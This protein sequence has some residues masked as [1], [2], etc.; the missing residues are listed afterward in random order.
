MVGQSQ[1]GSHRTFFT[2]IQLLQAGPACIVLVLFILYCTTCCL[3]SEI[4]RK[5]LVCNFRQA[6]SLGCLIDRHMARNPGHLSPRSSTR[7]ILQNSRKNNT[8][9]ERRAGTQVDYLQLNS[10]SS[11]VLFDTARK[12]HKREKLY[13]VER[14]I[15]R[16]KKQYVRFS[17]IKFFLTLSFLCNLDNAQCIGRSF[18]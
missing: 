18:P 8:A 16:R 10:L 7:L 9:V 15:Q 13:D 2:G 12:K 17:V 11:V 3:M 5:L 4:I 14:I 6:I 1:F